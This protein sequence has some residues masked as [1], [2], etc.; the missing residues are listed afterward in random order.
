MT[1]SIVA[2][3]NRGVVNTQLLHSVLFSALIFVP[4]RLL[5][6]FF[7]LY[8]YFQYIHAAFEGGLEDQPPGRGLPRRDACHA[9]RLGR[10]KRLASASQLGPVSRFYSGSGHLT[11]MRA[12]SIVSFLLG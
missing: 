1:A 2:P 7:A 10:G 4:F 11:K 5:R 8:V 3:V 12:S 6:D 9:H